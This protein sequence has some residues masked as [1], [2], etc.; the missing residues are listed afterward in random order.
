M[1]VLICP[2][3]F[4]GTLTAEEAAA[5]IARGWKQ[6]RPKDRLTLLPVSDGGDGF[7]AI[8][9]R[10]LGARPQKLRTVNAAHEPTDSFWW[11]EPKSKTAIIESARINGLAMLPKGRF[12]PFDLNTFGL[13]AALLSAAKKGAKKALIGIGGSATNDAGFGLARA[14]GWKFLDRSGS[15]IIEWLKLAGLATVT[16]PKGRAVIPSI[17]VAVDVQNPL[18]GARGCSRVYGPQKGLQ[19]EDM[20]PAETALRRLA[21]VLREQ[22]GLGDVD[23]PGVGAAGGLGFGLR[24]FAGARLKPGF[25][26]VANQA[27]LKQL[28]RSADLVITGEGALDRQ[29][30]MGKGVGEIA[31]LSRKAGVP[32]V[33]LAGFV[34]NPRQAARLFE[35]TGA[36]LD[37]TDSESAMSQT[38]RWLERL[39]GKVAEGCPPR[40]Y[41]A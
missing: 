35:T 1:N 30:L 5:A 25:D 6:A 20:K 7:G 3:K 10:L 8:M 39:A 27:G 24:V 19:P 9:A 29:T 40:N 23:E 37:L 26:L 13:G 16:R 22:H 38:A 33:G 2:D 11:W 17:I 15:E 36:L 31:V 18:L 12:H 34:E 14:L 41:A 4:K 21:R 28:I 32:C